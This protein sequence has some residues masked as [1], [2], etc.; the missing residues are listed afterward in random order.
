M[1]G[2]GEGEGVRGGTEGFQGR[3]TVLSDMVMV[4]TG[5]CTCVQTNRMRWSPN[6]NHRL[7]AVANGGLSFV[8]KSALREADNVRCCVR[9][10]QGAQNS[11][12]L[13]LSFAVNLKLLEKVV[14][15]K[16]KKNLVASILGI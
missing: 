16:K 12:Y 6:V 3:K 11:L 15:E 5:H 1:P 4:D 10:G 2:P 7:W 9:V 14:F 8:R 13:P